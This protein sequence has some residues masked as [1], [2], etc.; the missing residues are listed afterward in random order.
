[1]KIILL[2]VLPAIFLENKVYSCSKPPGMNTTTS[3]VILTWKKLPYIRTLPEIAVV[4]TP[5]PMSI[6]APNNTT[7]SNTVRIF[8]C[9]SRNLF[10]GEEATDCVE[11]PYL[12]A[13][14]SSS[15]ACW[16]ASKLNFACLQS[17][18]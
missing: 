12:Y 14:S 7:R 16:L 4:S 18:E 6:L 8:L 11:G 2:I 1:M 5:S 9:F 17:S 3:H 15:A 10:S 13:E